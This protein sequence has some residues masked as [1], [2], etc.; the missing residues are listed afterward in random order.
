MSK[1]WIQILCKNGHYSTASVGD[2]D[3][4]D[5]CLVCGEEFVWSNLVNNKGEQF[6]PNCNKSKIEW[7][8]KGCSKC[9]HGR[10]DGFIKLKVSTPN[11]ILL[12][13]D[14]SLKSIIYTKYEIP[15]GNRWTK[16]S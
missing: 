3:D 8:F 5:R 9:N 6:C 2:L 14:G 4:D 15:R 16:K 1:Y 12:H 13:P 10:V 11:E 7:L